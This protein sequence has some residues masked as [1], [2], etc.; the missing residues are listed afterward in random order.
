M[1]GGARNAMVMNLGH[2]VYY[3]DGVCGGGLAIKQ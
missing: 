1:I 3:I 2:F